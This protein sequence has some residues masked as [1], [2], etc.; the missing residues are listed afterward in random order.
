MTNFLGVNIASLVNQH[1]GPRVNRM[2]L[3]KVTRGQRDV[4]NPTSGTI[5]TTSQYIGSGFVEDYDERVID[6]D[7]VLATDRKIIMLANS[8][9]LSISP[10]VG[11]MISAPEG[12]FNVVRVSRDPARAVF[13]IQARSAR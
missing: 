1:L 6:G 9:P 4:S 3:I 13:T 2:T 7:M 11:D 5:K 10:Q 12:V 8:I